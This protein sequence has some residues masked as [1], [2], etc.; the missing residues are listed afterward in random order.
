MLLLDERDTRVERLT[1]RQRQILEPVARGETDAE[2]AAALVLSPA[3]VGKHLEAIF[4][5][6]RVHTRTVAAAVLSPAAAAPTFPGR[7]RA[8]HR[9]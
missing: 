3:T 6:L 2:I 5:R 1:R 8:G 9:A 4:T 7:G